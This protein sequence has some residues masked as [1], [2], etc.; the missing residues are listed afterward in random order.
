MARVLVFSETAGFRHVSGINA[1]RPAIE[2]LG[3]MH[4]FEVDLT[5]DSADFNDAN[6]A[7]YDAVVWL[8]TTGNV[9]NEDEQAAFQRYSR[10]GGGYVGIHS[11]SDTHHTWEWYG[12]LVG[13]YFRNH[14]AQQSATLVVA[15]RVH[16]STAGLP[17]VWNRFDEWYNFNLNPRGNVHV[18][19]SIDETSYNP[20]F[21]AMGADHPMAWCHAYDGGRS[22]YTALGHGGSAFS[23]PL[24]LDHILGGIR[25]LKH[26]EG[27][28]IPGEPQ[29]EV[30]PNPVAESEILNLQADRSGTLE[31]VSVLGQRIGTPMVMRANRLHKVTL[32]G[33]AAGIYVLKFS[34]GNRSVTRRV[35]IQ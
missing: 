4:G 8:S 15:D 7:R 30:Y 23:E 25:I 29:L 6:L 35:I 33:L 31:V 9:L 28:S 11:A 1:G 19:L 24:F 21:G 32:T 17:T 16:P 18:L 2:A 22:W 20:G 14:P 12:G 34:A 13:A 27:T 5:E 10:N 3:A 26:D